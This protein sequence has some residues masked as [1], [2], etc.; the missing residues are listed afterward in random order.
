MRG[1]EEEA[2]Q[3]ILHGH[4]PQHQP[5]GGRGQDYVESSGKYLVLFCLISLIILM[6]AQFIVC[7]SNPQVGKYG[8]YA[9]ILVFL[10]QDK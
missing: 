8:K 10:G 5:A 3:T 2:S 9:K 6:L 4:V 1:A 7:R